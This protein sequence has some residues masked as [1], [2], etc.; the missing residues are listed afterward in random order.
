[1]DDARDDGARDFDFLTGRWKVHNRRL[2]E[3]LKGSTEW[4][5]FEATQRRASRC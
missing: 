1:M 5:E 2:C 3:R 4:E